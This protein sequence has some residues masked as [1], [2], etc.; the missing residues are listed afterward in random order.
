MEHEIPPFRDGT[1]G[2]N[3]T[4]TTIS[5]SFEPTR[6]SSSTCSGNG[7]GIGG[8]EAEAGADANKGN[9]GKT[10]AAVTTKKN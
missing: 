8:G 10:P 4:N 5:K 1:L 3:S 6:P 7:K 9:K 2:T